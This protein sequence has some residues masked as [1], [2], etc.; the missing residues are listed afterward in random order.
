M[1]VL[2]AALGQATAA[3]VPA[4]GGDDTSASDDPKPCVFRTTCRDE[5]GRPLAF[6]IPVVDSPQRRQEIQLAD[7]SQFP[8]P[9]PMTVKAGNVRIR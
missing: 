9:P 4:T 5:T 2:S 6:F 7:S 1:P 8:D 3:A